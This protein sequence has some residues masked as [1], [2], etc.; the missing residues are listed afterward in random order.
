MI[1]I[2]KFNDFFNEKTQLILIIGISKEKTDKQTH[3]VPFSLP[4][5]STPATSRNLATKAWVIRTQAS[6]KR[7]QE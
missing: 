1:K 5:N 4:D 6:L 2:S 7:H 3:T